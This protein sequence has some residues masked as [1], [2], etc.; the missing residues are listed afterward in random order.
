MQDGRILLVQ[1]V[2]NLYDTNESTGQGAEGESAKLVLI[3]K[4]VDQACLKES[5]LKTLG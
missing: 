2:R 4:G 3:G 1:G 5:L